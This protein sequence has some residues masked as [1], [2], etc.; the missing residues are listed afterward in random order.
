MKWVRPSCC[1]GHVLQTSRGTTSP[2]LPAESQQQSFSLAWTENWIR[3]MNRETACDGHPAAGRSCRGHAN[4]FLQESSA[5]LHCDIFKGQFQ[6]ESRCSD[7]TGLLQHRVLKMSLRMLSED[8]LVVKGFSFLCSGDLQTVNQPQV[9]DW[10]FF[11]QSC[12]KE[13][14]VYIM[15]RLSAGTD[16][17]GIDSCSLIL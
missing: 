4:K 7:R 5:R 16:N 1:G 17:R 9:W 13:E 6:H 10:M 11:C 12:D 3:R 14:P 2:L 8:S 15:S